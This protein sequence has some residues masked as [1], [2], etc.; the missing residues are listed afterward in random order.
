IDD[1][2]PMS[3]A[4]AH[5]ELGTQLT[6]RYPPGDWDFVGAV[7]ACCEDEYAV[8]VPTVV[9]STIAQGVYYTTFFLRALTGTPGVYFDAPPDSGYSID[10]LAPAV[11]AGLAVN[12]TIVSGNE[13]SWEASEDEDFQHFRVYR[14]DSEEFEPSPENL[15][16]MTIAAAWLDPDGTP[17]HYYRVTALDHAGNESD[18]ASPESVTGVVEPA[19]PARFALHRS[20][21][22]PL[23]SGTAIAYDVPASGGEVRLTVYDVAG[24]RVRTLVDGPQTVG[25]MSA[26]WDGRDDRGNVVGS[27]VYYCRLEAPGCE[28]SIK[29]TVLR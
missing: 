28:Q 9:D 21:P 11:P 4:S 20:V 22:N 16:H 1:D 13:L 6:D 7:P 14:D 15:I 24:R 19:I 8:V 25:R 26:T 2:I 10:N 3:R 17:L 5:P 23:R 27:G 18:P 29:I 12:Y